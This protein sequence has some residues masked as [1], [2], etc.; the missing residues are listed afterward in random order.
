MLKSGLQA[1]P[2]HFTT[3]VE[4]DFLNPATGSA[5]WYWRHYW[6]AARWRGWELLG[7]KAWSLLRPNRH[8][9]SSDRDLMNTD[10]LEPSYHVGLVG[11]RRRQV[12]LTRTLGGQNLALA[13]EN[14]GNYTAKVTADRGLGH[15][16]LAAFSGRSRRRGVSAAAVVPVAA[17]L[18]VVTQQFWS[19]R[20]I[21]EALGIVP[22]RVGGLATIQGVEVQATRALEVYSYAGMVYGSRSAGNR[23]ARS[24]SAGA[25]YRRPVSE[26]YGSVA[27]SLE[28]SYVDR[29]L[30]AGPSGS[31]QYVMYGLRYRFN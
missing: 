16:E 9:T 29:A 13:W 6:A 2:V 31:L 1:G 19:N 12:R 5:P 17:R 8:G 30:W 11:A 7:G 4:S 14:N 18:R 26:W 24:W 27:L 25:S 10:A 23:T 22:A 3:Y 28:Y 20:D 15:L 21:N